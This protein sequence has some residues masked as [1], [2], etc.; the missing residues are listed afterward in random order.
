CSRVLNQPPYC[1]YPKSAQLFRISLSDGLKDLQRSLETLAEIGAANVNKYRRVRQ[2][3]IHRFSKRKINLVNEVPKWG[4]TLAELLLDPFVKSN[5]FAIF[6][7]CRLRAIA[8][9]KSFC[10]RWN[11]SRQTRVYSSRRFEVGKFANFYC[12]FIEPRKGF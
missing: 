10:Y 5:S 7:D 12:V 11:L 8:F 9:S 6:G 2:S 3:H 1:L 4:W